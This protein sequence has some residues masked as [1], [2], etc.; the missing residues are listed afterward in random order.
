MVDFQS[1]PVRTY[2]CNGIFPCCHG[3][4]KSRQLAESKER[5]GDSAW[6]CWLR[7]IPYAGLPGL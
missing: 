4:K 7:I 3:G 2:C 6:R 5:A 1:D